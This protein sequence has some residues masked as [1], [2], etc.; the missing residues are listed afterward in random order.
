MI[1][2]FNLFSR[3]A[4]QWLSPLRHFSYGVFVRAVS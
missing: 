4:S 3:S 1:F 2:V